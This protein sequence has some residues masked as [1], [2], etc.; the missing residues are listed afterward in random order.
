M[1]NSN[2][3]I[4]QGS[5]LEQ[6]NKGRARVKVAVFC[7]LSFHLLL[8]GALLIQGCNKPDKSDQTSDNTGAGNTNLVGAPADTNLAMPPS[9]PASNIVAAP[10]PTNTYVAPPTQ[11]PVDLGTK[12]YVVVKG[13]ILFTIAK[14]FGVSV[15][16]VENAN[17]GLVPTKLK[18]GQ[19]LQIPA[20]GAST[21]T[22]ASV[23]SPS[24]MPDS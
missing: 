22:M 1:N 14:K 15:K 11:A 12:E 21:G 2:P 8:L 18:V 23:G 24:A 10:P 5:L 16:A 3:L 17:P 19:K 6:K 13:D 7:V 20:A 4:P 9:G